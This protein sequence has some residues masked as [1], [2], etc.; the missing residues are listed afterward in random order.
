LLT[1][2]LA[3]NNGSD[4]IGRTLDAFA[5]LIA[6]QGGWKLVIVNNA[7]TDAT[8]SIIFGKKHL[9]PLD[10][11]TEPKVG[12]CRALNAGFARIDGDLVVLTDDDVLPDRNWLVEWRRVADAHPDIAVFGGAIVP[13]FE[14]PPPAWL[15]RTNWTLMLYAATTPG[16]PEGPMA[17]NAAEVFGPNWAIR[18][19]V[20]ERGTRFEEH[21]MVGPAAL[22]GDETAFLERAVDQ[23]FKVG[24]AP[25]ARVRHIVGTHQVRWWWMLRRFYRH[26]RTTFILGPGR[27]RNSVPTLFGIPRYLVKRIA[28]YSAGLPAVAMSFDALKLMSRLR[29]IAYDLGAAR[30]ARVLTRSK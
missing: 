3:T 26:G 27:S 19:E 22:M 14:A 5:E 8:E 7:S 24:F 13:H 20:V 25:K 2:L 18:S 4:T 30:Q 9:L 10:Y 6:P 16:R 29:L 17:P 15:V 11:M 23:G 21:Y 28:L 1:V 12:K